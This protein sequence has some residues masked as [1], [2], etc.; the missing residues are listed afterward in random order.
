MRH[1]P[2]PSTVG[3][4]IGHEIEL[5][6][7]FLVFHF[8][9]GKSRVASGTPVDDV[10]PFVNQILFVE[11]HENFTNGP[12]KSFVHGEALSPP[13]AG[14]AELLELTD[15][16]A[17]VLFLPRPD[18]L[19]EGLSSYVVTGKAFL[20]QVS[21][22]NVLRGDARMVPFQEARERCIRTYVCNDR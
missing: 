21:L 3:E 6:G 22:H 20:G 9:I 10:F 2:F 18:P 8:E 11:L 13:V 16:S 4:G 1:T 12:G 7:R 5:A 19:F 14:G 17:S 15:D